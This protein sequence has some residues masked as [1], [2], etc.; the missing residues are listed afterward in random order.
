MHSIK[1]NFILLIVNIYHLNKTYKIP[2]DTCTMKF[3]APARPEKTG[4][5]GQ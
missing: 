1:L 3:N 5:T 2:Y 4:Y